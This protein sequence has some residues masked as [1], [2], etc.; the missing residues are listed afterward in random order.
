MIIEYEFNEV[1]FCVEVV[2]AEGGGGTERS[3]NGSSCHRLFLFGSCGGDGGM[4]LD[5]ESRKLLVCV[6]QD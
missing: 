6:A 3:I 1:D 5:E 4:G 2:E